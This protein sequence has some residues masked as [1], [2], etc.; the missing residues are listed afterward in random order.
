[1]TTKKEIAISYPALVGIVIRERR[2][3]AG[4]NQRAIAQALGVAQTQY[5]RIESGHST[6]NIRQ[7]NVIAAA[8]DSSPVDLIVRTEVLVVGLKLLG[9]V[10]TEYGA[11]SKDERLAVMR[12]LVQDRN[13]RHQL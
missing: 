6:I 2:E 11:P 5:S 7:L 13:L 10:I 9:V 1:M 3:L 12:I 8:V 4:K